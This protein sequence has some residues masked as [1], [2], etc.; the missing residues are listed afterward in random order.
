MKIFKIVFKNIENYGILTISLILIYEIINLFKL[1]KLNLFYDELKTNS[2]EEARLSPKKFNGP[3]LATPFYILNI[4]RKEIGKSNFTDY[5]FIDFGCGAC[6]VLNYFN[7]YFKKLIGIDINLKF[8]NNITSN[9]QIFINLDLRKIKKLKKII[10]KTKYVLYFY[11]PFDLYLTKKIIQLFKN[12]TVIIITVN[13]TKIVNKRFKI[14]F[15]KHFRSIKKNI[16][17]Y[18]NSY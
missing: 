7:N 15:I 13:V 16:I 18:K 12:N 6:R 9:K 14:I 4:I 5:I 10:K 3:Y 17:I 8:K 1:K 11:E 2:Y